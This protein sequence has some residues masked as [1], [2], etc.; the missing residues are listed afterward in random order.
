MDDFEDFGGR[1]LGQE[2]RLEMER[3]NAVIQIRCRGPNQEEPA[4]FNG[5]ASHKRPQFF[6]LG[7]G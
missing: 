3:R 6:G 2:L 4:P 1:R 7:L 5:L